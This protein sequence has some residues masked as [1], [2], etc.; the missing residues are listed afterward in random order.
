MNMTITTKDFTKNES[1]DLMNEVSLIAPVDTPL[2]TY[3]LSKNKVDRAYATVVSWREKTLSDS[4]SEL[5]EGADITEFSAS[6]RVE[7]NNVCQIFAKGVAVS[8]TAQA[9]GVKGINDLL[10]E[11]TQ[12][13]LKEI[14]V[15]M[16][17]A[18]TAGEFD[19]GTSTGIRKMKGLSSFVTE[20][21]TVKAAKLTEAQFKNTVKKIWEKG[22]T[23]GEFLALVNA[24]LKEDL[25]AIYKD[26]YFYQA[27]TNEFG[28]VVHKVITNYGVVN[29]MLSRHVPADELIIVDEE[30]L[31][32]A[33]LREPGFEDLGKTGDS[34]KGMVVAEGA[35]KLTN[36]NAAAKFVKG[37]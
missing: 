2:T 19:D 3:L 22:N 16:E 4:A 23:N 10:A 34:V 37:A 13:R 31:R 35:L 6:K 7:R 15:D 20:E 30:Y 25:D 18:L 36:E 24:D 8:G 1:I 29:V 14:K 17:V 5:Q 28:L 11:E 12:D 9:I 21:N 33:F 32:I 27:E 26:A